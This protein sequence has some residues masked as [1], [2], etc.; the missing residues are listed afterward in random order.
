MNENSAN[1]GVMDFVRAA[2]S[3][4][5]K[6][7]ADGLVASHLPGN[8]HSETRVKS[9]RVRFTGNNSHSTFGHFVWIMVER[10][11]VH[12]T[13]AHF[14]DSQGQAHTVNNPLVDPVPGIFARTNDMDFMVGYPPSYLAHTP[15][16]YAGNLIDHIAAF[17]ADDLRNQDSV[18]MLLQIDG[19]SAS[20]VL[21]LTGDSLSGWM[22]VRRPGESITD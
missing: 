3:A 18:E 12:G 19:E 7:T 17:L 10:G 22:N 5:V 2:V 4:V 14:T 8:Q 16:E 15:L 20:S 11:D 13:L 6:M 1:S 21:T 9:A